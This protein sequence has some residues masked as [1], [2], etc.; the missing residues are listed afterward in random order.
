MSLAIAPIA[1]ARLTVRQRALLLACDC[2]GRTWREVAFFA[3]VNSECR[4][5]IEDFNEL[6]DR[7]LL[8]WE[9]DRYTLTQA[10]RE[11]QRRVQDGGAA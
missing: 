11:A 7:G 2:R 9:G 5:T 1:V 8:D 3:R 4:D 6:F 10:G